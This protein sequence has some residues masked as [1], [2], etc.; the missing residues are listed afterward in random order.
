M[1]LTKH[2]PFT[3][4][5]YNREAHYSMVSKLIV[6]VQ[7]MNNCISCVSTSLFGSV[8]LPPD[9]SGDDRRQDEYSPSGQSRIVRR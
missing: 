1:S 4:N 5:M 3:S 7:N 6:S 8:S 9:Q 2:E